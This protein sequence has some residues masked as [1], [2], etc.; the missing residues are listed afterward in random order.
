MSC[1]RRASPVDHAVELFSCFGQRFVRTRFYTRAG[2]A[3]S[4]DSVP[5]GSL[6]RRSMD[7]LSV[8]EYAWQSYSTKEGPFSRDDNTFAPGPL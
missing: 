4:Y 3:H 1:P 6:A 5:S 8:H 7:L 2:R